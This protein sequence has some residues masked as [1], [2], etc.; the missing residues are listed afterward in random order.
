MPKWLA[1]DSLRVETIR[2]LGARDGNNEREQRE[3][4]S[5]SVGVPPVRLFGQ[6]RLE[7]IAGAGFE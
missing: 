7:E 2:I 4:A 6:H 5:R 1:E 3:L